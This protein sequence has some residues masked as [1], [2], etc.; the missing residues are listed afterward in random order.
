MTKK[1]QINV[2]YLRVIRFD[3]TM[4]SFYIAY[5]SLF[6]KN[7]GAIISTFPRYLLDVAFMTVLHHDIYT[8]QTENKTG[9][10]HS[11]PDSDVCL[12]FLS[13]YAKTCVWFVC[14]MFVYGVMQVYCYV[15]IHLKTLSVF[16]F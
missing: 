3:Y 6:K 5:S 13:N 7:P 8:K 2:S 12:F 15:L 4:A 16:L 9:A 1:R 11:S 14:G 10:S